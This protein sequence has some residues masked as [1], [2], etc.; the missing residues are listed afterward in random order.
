VSKKSLEPLKEH[1]AMTSSK[2]LRL[3]NFNKHPSAQETKGSWDSPEAI[4]KAIRADYQTFPDFL[5]E[6][7][8]KA[9]LFVIESAICSRK[10]P[11]KDDVDC[12]R[13]CREERERRRQKRDHR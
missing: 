13:Y 5:L 12:L 6:Q 1:H 7:Q 10:P 4:E 9:I 8:E 3:E 11:D 2:P